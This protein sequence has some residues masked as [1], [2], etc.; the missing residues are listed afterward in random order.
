MFVARC[1]LYFKTNNKKAIHKTAIQSADMELLRNYF[2]DPSTDAIKLQEYVW[3]SLCFHFGRRGREGWRDLQKEHFIVKSDAKN[4]SYVTM[5]VTENH[6]GGNKQS[7]QDYSDVRMYQ[8]V[9]SPLDPVRC[10]T[11]YKSKL[12]DENS[13]L[14]AKNLKN[15]SMQDRTWYGR[16]V[17][18][19]NTIST[20]MKILSQKAGLSQLYTNH[21]VRASTVTGLF[22]AGVDTQQIC[23][24]TKHR[25]ESTLAHY[26]DSVSDE[27]KEQ[28][29]SVLSMALLGNKENEISAQPVTNRMSSTPSPKS[30]NLLQH[31]MNNANFQNCTINFYGQ[32][33]KQM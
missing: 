25:S 7:E 31:I 3:F 4:R 8:M 2:G 18:G 14:F 13:F 6:S 17:I 29:S 16:E 33:S 20:I 11:L 12:H 15:W 24:I 19:K 32:S 26:I 23:S 28:A 9:S 1:K 10:F 21:C 30:A 5:D 22:R 27:Q